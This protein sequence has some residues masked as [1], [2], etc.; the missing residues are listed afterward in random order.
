MNPVLVEIYSTILPAAPYVIGAYALMF[1]ALFV[2]VFMVVR[3]LKKTEKQM[4]VLEE[5][6][7]EQRRD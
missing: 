7:E 1:L 6:I 4:A 2:Y 5:A 3:G